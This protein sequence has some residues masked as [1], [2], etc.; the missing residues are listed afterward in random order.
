M[1]L[2]K[3]GVPV[4][5]DILGDRIKHRITYVTDKELILTHHKAFIIINVFYNTII[6]TATIKNK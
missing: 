4:L 2:K 5:V 1:E 6:P 3:L